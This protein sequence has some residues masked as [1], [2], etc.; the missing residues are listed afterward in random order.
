MAVGEQ[1]VGQVVVGALTGTVGL[2]GGLSANTVEV[3]EEVLPIF[4][5]YRIAAANKGE[6]TLLSFLVG[7]NIATASCGL[8][9]SGSKTVDI[10]GRGP[11]D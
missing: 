6:E 11:R 10:D 1:V 7:L 2:N 5:T 3:N 8:E 4:L 9:V